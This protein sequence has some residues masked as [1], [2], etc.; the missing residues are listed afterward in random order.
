MIHVILSFVEENDDSNTWQDSC[1]PCEIPVETDGN[2]QTEDEIDWAALEAA[3][4]ENGDADMTVDPERL[5]E[6]ET[7]EAP[8][9]KRNR[10][11]APR[12]NVRKSCKR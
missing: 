6:L 4:Q 10:V 7:P 8:P 9:K 11:D 5:A 2:N 12:K 1:N 3:A